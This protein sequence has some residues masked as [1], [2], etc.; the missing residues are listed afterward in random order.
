MHDHELVLRIHS[1]DTVR[2][3]ERTRS[4]IKTGLYEEGRRDIR[5]VYENLSRHLSDRDTGSVFIAAMLFQ[6]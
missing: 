1:L 6:P 4:Q 2:A 3:I 5:N